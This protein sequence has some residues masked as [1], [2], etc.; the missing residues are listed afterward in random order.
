[1]KVL[2]S[3]AGLLNGTVDAEGEL[4]FHVVEQCVGLFRL[5]DD[6]QFFAFGLVEFGKSSGQ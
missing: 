5:Y 1:M 3:R 6:V 4:G 2:K